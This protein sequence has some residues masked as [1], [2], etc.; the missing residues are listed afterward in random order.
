MPGLLGMNIMHRLYT[1]LY[2]EYGPALFSIPQVTQ[3]APGWREALQLYHLMETEQ[4]EE[5]LA[6]IPVQIPPQR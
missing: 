6:Q 2:E 5:G 1:D 3:A 4:S